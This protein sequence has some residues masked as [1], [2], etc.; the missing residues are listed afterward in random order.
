MRKEG[1]QFELPS[2][3]AGPLELGG[4][5]TVALSISNR[6]GACIGPCSPSLRAVGSF[7][8]VQRWVVLDRGL[9]LASSDTNSHKEN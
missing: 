8:T 9:K 5:S 6:I 2:S 1:P 4:P 7:P 3:A